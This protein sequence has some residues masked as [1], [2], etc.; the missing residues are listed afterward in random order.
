MS[1][2]RLLK[3]R[4]TR[5][6]V[7]PVKKRQTTPPF[8]EELRKRSEAPT[9]PPPPAD[10]PPKFSARVRKRTRAAATVDVVTA[11]LSR[12]GRREQDD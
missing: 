10:E 4:K 6:S 1:K 7:R 12:D 9:L 11:D 8:D 2:P 3:Q 5:P